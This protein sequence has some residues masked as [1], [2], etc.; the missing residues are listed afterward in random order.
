MHCIDNKASKNTCSRK[1]NR[2]QGN[3]GRR[4][5]YKRWRMEIENNRTIDV[6]KG[7]TGGLFLSV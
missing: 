5:R 3:S 6:D 1:V 4:P 2:M 7:V